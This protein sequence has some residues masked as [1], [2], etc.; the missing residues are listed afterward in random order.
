MGL[1]ATDPDEGEILYSIIFDSR[2][3]IYLP[4][5]GGAVTVSEEFAYNIIVGNASTVFCQRL[6]R[7]GLV[8]A[9]MLKDHSHK[10]GS[11]GANIHAMDVINALLPGMNT[12]NVQ[13]TL[14]EAEQ[15]GN[16]I[17]RNMLLAGPLTAR[18]VDSCAAG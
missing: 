11:N 1:F 6:I 5:E 14:A 10:G 9:A 8:T 3:P 13:D 12:T 16:P 7:S 2:R 17:G 4:P 15:R 18:G